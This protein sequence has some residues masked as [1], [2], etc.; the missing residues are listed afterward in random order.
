MSTPFNY[1]KLQSEVFSLESEL[2]QLPLNNE[3]DYSLESDEKKSGLLR[4]LDRIK[5]FFKFL[6]S[7]F[8]KIY[9]VIKQ[10]LI[11]YLMNKKTRD[12]IYKVNQLL[13]IDYLSDK[14]ITD[15]VQS[16]FRHL[17]FGDAKNAKHLFQKNGHL[18]YIPDIISSLSKTLDDCERVLK[19]EDKDTFRTEWIKIGGVN[20]RINDIAYGNITDTRSI[21]EL[22]LGSSDVDPSKI[23]FKKGMLFKYTKVMDKWY[24]LSVDF[25]N[26]SSA[27]FEK[28]IKEIEKSIKEL[29]KQSKDNDDIEVS[30]QLSSMLLRQRLISLV[31]KLAYL[32][33]SIISNYSRL[34]A[35]LT[36]TMV[37][38]KYTSTTTPPSNEKLYHLSDSN[39]IDEVMKPRIGGTNHN[40]F[41]PPR[42]SFSPD[43]LGACY[44]IPRYFTYRKGQKKGEETYRDLYLYEATPEK[45]KT[46]YLKEELVKYS[47]P[48]TVHDIVKEVC[49]TSPVKVKLVGKV[50]VFYEVTGNGFLDQG[51]AF[52]RGRYKRYEIIDE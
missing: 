7:V 32:P 45:G 40:E 10:K 22:I 9:K 15:M 29:E 35:Y 47:L 24:D 49:I 39:K 48:G 13:D 19:I 51:D 27:R 6:V 26:K 28:Q 38:V 37:D 14:D 2:P 46:R 17:I 44:A 52:K 34:V 16:F 4:K 41:M 5:D 25:Y 23:T 18:H 31:L 30:S 12:N 3:L 33:A 11:N 20:Y 43:I 36:S 21:E 50:R 1:L 42:I 8:T